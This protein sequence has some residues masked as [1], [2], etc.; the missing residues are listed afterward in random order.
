[1]PR[2]CSRRSPTNPSL[3]KTV[4]FSKLAPLYDELRQGNHAALVDLLVREGDLRGTRV[5]DVGCGTGSLAVT[6]AE[7]YACK[8]WGV[9][10]S[11]EMLDVARAKVPA[12][13]GLKLGRAEELPFKDGWFE[14]VV[15]T[16]AVHLWDRPRAFSEV[17][18]V[19]AAGGRFALASFNPAHFETYYLN[20][21]FPSILEIDTARFAPAEVLEAELGDAGFADTRSA[22]LQHDF[23]ISRDDALARIRGRHISTFQLIPEDEYA[24]GLERAERELPERV[25]FTQRWLVVSAAVLASS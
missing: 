14:R 18:R 5:L 12:G 2:S 24:A 19:L 25:H 13:V 9:D 8:V 20:A 6:L 16:L 17:H 15:A 11:P 21:F 3:S 23:S 22:D 1:M 7:Q 4:S 10:A